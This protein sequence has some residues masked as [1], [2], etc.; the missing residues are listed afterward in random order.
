[1]A[2]SMAWLAVALS[3]C[4]VAVLQGCGGGGDS[5]SST[6]TTT[7]TTTTTSQLR[8]AT[9]DTVKDVLTA[10]VMTPQFHTLGDVKPAGVRDKFDGD[11]SNDGT[12]RSYKAVVI[13]YMFGG[14][15]TYNMLVP[16]NCDK[17]DE[18]LSIRRTVALSP[19]KLNRIQ[20]VN[21]SCSEFG[22]HKRLPYIKELYDMK[23]AAFV[24][25]VG[26]MVEPV[27]DR[28]GRRKSG[29]RLCPGMFSH[30]DMQQA[31]MT[32]FC[33][34]GPNFKHGGGGRMADNLALRG[35]TSSSFSLAGKS[36]WSE[37]E[38]M[39]RKV[40]GA[41]DLVDEFKP[42]GKVQRIVDN[43]TSIEFSTVYAKEY[44]QQLEDTM[45]SYKSVSEALRNG[46]RLLALG[47]DNDYGAM[48]EFKQVARLIAAR[49]DRRAERDFFFLGIGGW[50]MHS[51][52]EA[53]LYSRLAMVDKGV[54]AFVKEM[55]AQLIWDSVVV[56]SKSDFARTLDPNANLGSDHAWAGNQFVLSGAINGGRVYN[57]FPSLAAGNPA[58]VGRG[59]LIPKHPYESYMVPI[60]KWLG[61]D[62]ARLSNIFPNLENF[63]MTYHIIPDLFPAER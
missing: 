14:A 51:T 44:V 4:I 33:Q 7:T 63:D 27:L 36:V 17:Y 38:V 48:Q 52:L 19:D 32:L 43:I 11:D 45:D 50:D 10:I 53:R 40:I 12:T 58:D 24:S 62:D 6:T 30:N 28:S 26:V 9:L 5:G 18:Y 20:T 35:F 25:N 23:E 21:Q 54:A 59:R 42:S 46:D 1:M 34:M 37:G 41:A 56:A 31:S 3:A 22:I 61:V 60:A 15:D 39:R 57:E 55:K 49:R 8:N 13:L 16:L 2:L 29:A 47:D